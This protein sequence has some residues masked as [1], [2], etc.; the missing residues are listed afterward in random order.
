MSSLAVSPVHSCT[1]SSRIGLLGLSVEMGCGTRTPGATYRDKNSPCDFTVDVDPTVAAVHLHIRRADQDG[2]FQ[3]VSVHMEGVDAQDARVGAE[4]SVASK[5][6]SVSLR[7][8]EA[9][10]QYAYRLLSWDGKEVCPHAADPFALAATP[11]TWLDSEYIKAIRGEIGQLQS[12]GTTET[13]ISEMWRDRRVGEKSLPSSI[14]TPLMFRDF[15]PPWSI[16]IDP[17]KLLNPSQVSLEQPYGHGE[18]EIIKLHP[19]HSKGAPQD[20]VSPS[21]KYARGFI[22]CL[23]DSRYRSWLKQFGNTIEFFPLNPSV[24]E[25]ELFAMG[26][27]NVWGYMPTQLCALNPNYF[28]APDPHEQLKVLQQVIYECKRDGLSVICDVVHGHVAETQ[29]GP[30]FSL[31]VLHPEGYFLFGR[32]GRELDI[33]G[34]GD[35]LNSSSP[36]ALNLQLAQIRFY[37]KLLGAGCRIDQAATSGYEL[38]GSSNEGRFNP[39]NPAFRRIVSASSPTYLELMYPDGYFER[40]VPQDCGAQV[41]HFGLVNVSSTVA[42]GESRMWPN[43]TAVEWLA[44][45]VTGKCGGVHQAQQR[46]PWS[47]NLSVEVYCHDGETVF[48]RS[49]WHAIWI[50]RGR[51]KGDDKLTRLFEDLEA[52]SDNYDA[53]YRNRQPRH[54]RM[55]AIVRYLQ[56]NYPNEFE[57]AQG[58]VHRWYMAQLYTTSGDILIVAGD[59]MRRTQ[60]GDPNAFYQP[61]YI[62]NALL[63]DGS[64]SF[65]SRR[66]KN[67]INIWFSQFLTHRLHRLRERYR[68]IFRNVNI[69][70][71]RDPSSSDRSVVPSV[72]WFRA[73]GQ[74][75]EDADWKATPQGGKMQL[76]WVYDILNSET[77]SLNGRLFIFNSSVEGEIVVPSPGENRVWRVCVDSTRP[78]EVENHTYSHGDIY[79]MLTC[80]VVVME[81]VSN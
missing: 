39:N 8:V 49:R 54:E 31:R 7:G 22:E 58:E 38:A 65:G 64:N 28:I 11:F 3:V 15:T 17:S 69:V 43:Q 40:E 12:Q 27:S 42:Y 1:P 9:G 32:D 44:F 66:F 52:T 46:L 67:I 23:L 62:D 21:F 6:W 19:W 36:L 79:S 41:K 80:G 56:E 35:T 60:D 2:N 33:T 34:C 57:V 50:V 14:P 75:M 72:S 73:D 5:R 55:L 61:S 59:Q 4:G 70:N 47:R 63:E 37:S 74:P 29:I 78:L 53:M 13:A 68:S 16:V 18:R 45:I 71:G 26:R 51:I 24:T 81:S 10:D 48:D 77:R 25:P 20:A 76:G 30:H